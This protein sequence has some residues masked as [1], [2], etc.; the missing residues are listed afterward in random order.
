[1]W[2]DIVVNLSVTSDD[3]SA[4]DY[5]VA[6][7]KAYGAHVSGIA[8]AYE[9]ALP[10]VDTGGM[11]PALMEDQRQENE[12]IGRR[13]IGRFAE[14]AHAAGISHDARVIAASLAGA[15]EMFSEIARR[16]DLSVVGQAAQDTSAPE[17]LIVEGA[18]FGSGRPI[19][20]LPPAYTAGFS[21]ARI[22][23]CWNGGRTAARAM[24][25]AMPFLARA[26]HIDVVT[27]GTNAG[28]ADMLAHARID[29][30]LRRHGLA[31][32]VQP[33]ARANTRVS[34]AIL[35]HAAQTKADLIVMGGYGHSRLREFILGGTT[36]AVLG[37]TTVP[38]L[39]SH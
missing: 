36:R 32:T 9:P 26:E 5:A 33:I 19:L 13:V 31:F 27:V 8:F 29:D 39:M 25:D 6:L 18:L 4:A 24:A 21:L 1:M 10:V 15:P 28:K 2:K 34:T 11:S 3:S 17:E 14:K 23:L 7:G 35:E 22:M 30:H 20:V 16:Y 38:T 37:S 12:E